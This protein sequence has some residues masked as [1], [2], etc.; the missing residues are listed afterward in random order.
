MRSAAHDDTAHLKT[1]S[2]VAR[3]VVIRISM[4][5]SRRGRHSSDEAKCDPTSTVHRTSVQAII[6]A[7]LD[8]GV[9][10]GTDVLEA[11][12]LGARAV[13]IGRPYLW[14]LAAAGE[15]GVRRVLGKF[16]CGTGGR[17]GA[18]PMSD[19]R[20]DHAVRRY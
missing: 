4:T 16:P 20:P 9:R 8:G 18:G 14:S 7:F 13:L 1:V 19:S 17:D 2:A 6:R 3:I 15:T 5:N 10:R 12:A 11:L